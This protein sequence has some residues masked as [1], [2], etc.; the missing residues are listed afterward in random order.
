MPYP[1]RAAGGRSR[2]EPPS[3]I[4]L[5]GVPLGAFPGSLYD[6]VTFDLAVDD[7]Y[8][9]CSDG[10]FEAQDETADEFG[11][12]RLLRVVDDTRHL[13]ARDIVNAIFGAV[14]DFRGDTQA[15]DDMTAVALKITS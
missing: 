3:Q 8:V 13:G 6:E 9:F 15:N 1:I 2:S 14:Q 5:P 4:E 12:E 7:V 11:V 10:V